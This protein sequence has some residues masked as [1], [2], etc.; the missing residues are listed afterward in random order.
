[1]YFSQKFR[2]HIYSNNHSQAGQ[3]L[4]SFV[5]QLVLIV[6]IVVAI[7]WF[8]AEPFI[9][10]GS[11]MTPNFHD[12]QYLIIDKLSYHLINPHRG[13]VVVFRNPRNESEFYIKRIIGLP[14][15]TIRFTQGGI[16]ITNAEFP[17]G[18]VLEE[19]YLPNDFSTTGSPAP[20]TL[21]TD[22]YFVMGDN[23]T[24]NGS[25]DSRE[26]GAL[27]RFE[28]VGKVRLRLLPIHE[29]SLFNGSPKYY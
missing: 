17:E 2:K 14:G 16:E 15:E 19:K 25:S 12:G 1:V 29:F 8:V 4:G 28:I 9:V 21:G 24:P 22:D 6:A 18:R 11:S 3:A 20:Q 7:R 10:S 23:R 13:D 27:P 5:L 26:W